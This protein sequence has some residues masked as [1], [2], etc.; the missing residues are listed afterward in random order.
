MDLFKILDT[1]P[2]PAI[3]DPRT[4][5]VSGDVS[6]DYWLPAPMC[7]YQKELSEQIVSLHYS[8][9]LKYYETEDYNTDVVL[10]S[11]ETMC[12]NSQY[13]AT[14]PYL[15][16]DHG[17]PKSLITKDIPNHLAETSGKFG[18][19]KDLIG[20]IQDYQTETALV[21][22]SGRTMDLLEALLLG[23]KVNIKR[24][25]GQGIKIKQKPKK[26]SCTCHLFPSD[27]LPENSSTFVIDPTIH[28][29][30]LL[31]LDPSV[32][33]S[34]PHVQ[35]ILTQNR[36]LEGPEQKVPVVRLT[37]INSID[38]CELYYGKFVK[39]GSRDYLV[40]VTAAVVALRDVVGSL[41]P[42]LRP[43]YSQGLKYM[44]AWLEDPSI[45]WPLPDIYPIKAYT[46]MDVEKSLL[47]EV[48]YN[49]VD[50]VL[51]QALKSGRK[52][53]RKPNSAFP[54]DTQSPSYY[55]LKRLR[56]DYSTNSLKQD[57]A[58][59]TG[60]ANAK[61]GG[62][63][64]YHLS[65]GHLT[66]KLIQAIGESHY[67]LRRQSAELNDF[68]D[69]ET[70]QA[71]RM[72][73]NQEEH[74]DIKA[75][76]HDAMKVH[77]MNIQESARLISHTEGVNFEISDVE[78]E[79]ENLLKSARERGSE[80][81]IL[82]DLL[83][84]HV[85]VREESEEQ[86]KA[87]E[88]KMAEQ[89][90]MTEELTRAEEAIKSFQKDEE[91]LLRETNELERQIEIKIREDQSQSQKALDRIQSLTSQIHDEK[92]VLKSVEEQMET[93]TEHLKKIPYSR[94]RSTK[95]VHAPKQRHQYNS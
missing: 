51:A 92:A 82:V 42:D 15:L 58:Q 63:V 1:V 43:I 8:D 31:C 77:A 26:H 64:N 66:H 83:I 65:G 70:K 28:F 79:I 80:H 41:P 91:E 95:P 39:P 12:L 85:K 86:K 13:V 81:T 20:I 55:Q 56:N 25:S 40:K 88:S 44:R 60:I 29:D 67:K 59:L 3:V 57:M 22:R 21:C 16:I 90:Y 49:Q 48:H 14:H 72:K 93:L 50:D 17:V 89:K 10:H 32:D 78:K 94:V 38:H 74:D 53:G 36:P 18:V 47:T 73:T 46:P 45:P 24:Y 4:M 9:I 7:L 5:G 27:A 71:N 76:A 62:A 61:N 19:I 11:M 52:R 6:G 84:Q 34:R 35:Q 33:I 23:N 75:K 2:E 87:A 68:Y 30:L 54:K 69:A 37:T